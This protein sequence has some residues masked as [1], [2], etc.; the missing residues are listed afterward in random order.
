VL[1]KA[2]VRDRVL[3][4]TLF[5]GKSLMLRQQK[6]IRWRCHSQCTLLTLFLW[7]VT[8]TIRQGPMYQTKNK[9]EENKTKKRKKERKE[10]P[11]NQKD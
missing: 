9:K 1:Q 6:R 5:G 2:D 7:R 4:G 3:Y 11:K 10:K 8:D